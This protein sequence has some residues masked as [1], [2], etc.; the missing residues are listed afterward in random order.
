MIGLLFAGRGGLASTPATIR[1]LVFPIIFVLL[2]A[3]CR[4][5]P[6]PPASGSGGY[7]VGKHTIWP[8]LESEPRPDS[9][10]MIYEG[11]AVARRFRSP[12]SGPLIRGAFCAIASD[13]MERDVILSVC[14]A[15]NGRPDD[16]SRQAQLCPCHGLYA[17]RRAHNREA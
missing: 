9:Y 13:K 16:N 1:R 10:L 11:L 7:V 15:D 17:P 8:Q 6:P 5:E 2:L 4:G 3:G 12:A 14:A